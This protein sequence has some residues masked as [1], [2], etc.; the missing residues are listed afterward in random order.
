VL[1]PELLEVVDRTLALHPSSPSDQRTP[2]GQRTPD[3][4]Y[5]PD[6]QRTPEPLRGGYSPLERWQ[7]RLGVGA[8]AAQPLIGNA[9]WSFHADLAVSALYPLCRYAMIGVEARGALGAPHLVDTNLGIK[10]RLPI[11][12]DIAELYI[13]PIGGLTF[14]FQGD[15]RTGWNL[16]G[17]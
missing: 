11:F 8:G 6:D 15:T 16:G 12:G 17:H 3:G 4:Q 14:S 13:L 5:T 1:A 7:L 10:F 9:D 2:S